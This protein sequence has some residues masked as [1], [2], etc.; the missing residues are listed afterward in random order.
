[1]FG[2]LL[3][4]FAA[5]GG[6]SSGGVAMGSGRGMPSLGAEARLFETFC[7]AGQVFAERAAE[8]RVRCVNRHAD[9]P[10]MFDEPNLDTALAAA[11]FE[12][13]IADGER[14]IGR[15]GGR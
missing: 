15:F 10:A 5:A 8:M 13:D 7:E 3:L 9:F 6:L 2:V 12:L 1:M 11:E 4:A 14:S